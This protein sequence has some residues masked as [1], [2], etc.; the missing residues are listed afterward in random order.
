MKINK[1]KK[2]IDR[3]VLFYNNKGY[4]VRVNNIEVKD[5]VRLKDSKEKVYVI[6]FRES[7]DDNIIVSYYYK[8][9]YWD[10]DFNRIEEIK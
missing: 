9:K 7:K 8:K 2:K 1:L 10:V 5:Y 4:L 6:Y 3:N